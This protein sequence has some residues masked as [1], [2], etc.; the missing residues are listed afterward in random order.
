[1]Q[2]K[3]FALASLTQIS[4]AYTN[5]YVGNS[6]V[7]FGELPCPDSYRDCFFLFKQK[8]MKKNSPNR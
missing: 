8:E 1:M 3:G 4:F 2:A 6:A 7:G 5:A